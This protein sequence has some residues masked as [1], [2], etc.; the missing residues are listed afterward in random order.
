MTD[1]AETTPSGRGARTVAGTRLSVALVAA[2]LV[3]LALALAIV[4]R[5]PGNARLVF[6]ALAL[7]AGLPAALGLS[8]LLRRSGERFAMLLVGA[9]ALWSL[10]LL[11]QSSDSTAYSVGRIAVWLLEPVL[12]LLL[13]A[14]PHGRLTTRAERALAVAVA[15][16]AALLYLPT[17]LIADYPQPSPW[18]A[19]GTDCP[20]NAFMVTGSTPAVVDDLIRPLRETLTALLFAGV[21]AVL[22]GRAQR[23]GPVMR[24]ALVP[25]AA[26]AL[27]RAVV[28]PAYVGVRQAGNPSPL[29][30]ALGW[31]Y[32][33]SLPLVALAFAVGL[34]A[35][36]LFFADALRRL[37]QGLKPHAR[38]SDVRV[39]MASA[40]RD[41]SLQI[42]YWV[43][44]ERG[45]WVDENGWPVKPP[46]AEPGRAVTEVSSEG[47]RVA[48]IVHD[49]ELSDGSPLIE[50]ASAFALTS[51]E[52]ERLVTKLQA[53]LRDLSDSRARIA[54]VADRE[55]RNVERDL[56]DGAQQRLVALRIKLELVAETLD[57]D[58]PEGAAKL[59]TLEEEVDTTIDE[60]RSFARGVYPAVLSQRGLGEA[61]RAAGRSAAIPTSVD[62][63]RLGRYAPEIENAVYFACLEAL[64][65]AAKHAHGATGVRISLSGNRRLRF[66]VRDDGAGFD[67]RHS[68]EGGGFVNLRDRLAAVGG[69]LEVDSAPGQGTTVTGVIPVENVA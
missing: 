44:G 7:G 31:V 49:V 37:T 5:E 43:Q 35:Q 13:L 14:F 62:A 32:A 53:S 6:P 10:T 20:A 22:A 42:V 27:F 21:A 36:R 69:S 55:R 46:L 2:I 51:L 9:S 48:A 30:D 16:T 24:R 47:R 8:R 28:L 61:L 19:C 65:N 4:G 56:H 50:A 29:L 52:N 17:I 60:V 1:I 45:R 41:P 15:A 38:A 63:P 33:M 11:S 66:D 34:V 40:L 64:Q 12:V 67:A 54:A 18:A 57:S 39:A 25:V 68:T 26:V 59:R 58:S 3:G 23:S